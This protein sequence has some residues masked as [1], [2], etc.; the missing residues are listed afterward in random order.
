[1]VTTVPAPFRGPLAAP[2]QSWAVVSQ[3]LP[4][5]SGRKRARGGRTWGKLEAIGRHRKSDRAQ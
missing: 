2:I 1:M 4:I 3:S 5:Q